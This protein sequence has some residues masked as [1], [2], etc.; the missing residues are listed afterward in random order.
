MDDRQEVTDEQ[1]FLVRCPDGY[2]KADGTCQ[3]GRLLFKLRQR[4]ERETYVH[5]D[6]HIELYCDDCTRKMRKT[7]RRVK[8]VL[9]RYDFLGLLIETLIVEE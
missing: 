3:P 9:H 1:V 8:R 6:N 4:G 5:P 7:G 2:R